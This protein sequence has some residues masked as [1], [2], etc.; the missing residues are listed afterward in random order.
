MYMKY[1]NVLHIGRLIQ[2]RSVLGT[3]HLVLSGADLISCE[4]NCSSVIFADASCGFFYPIKMLSQS[5]TI[6]YET[7]Q[8]YI[9]GFLPAVRTGCMLGC[10]ALYE[11][12]SACMLCCCWALTVQLQIVIV[13]SVWTFTSWSALG[14]GNSIFILL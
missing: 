9:G 7:I 1:T 8:F 5:P 6:L 12:T 10:L 11:D 4:G 3:A 14:F 13:C 2:I